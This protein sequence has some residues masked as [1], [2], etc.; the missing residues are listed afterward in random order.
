[1]FKKSLIAASLALA[2]ASAQASV[3]VS[4]DFDGAGGL[5]GPTA[6]RALDWSPN[7]IL[8]TSTVAGKNAANPAVGD[9]VQTYAQA[10]LGSAIAAD[11]SVFNPLGLNNPSALGYEWTFVAGFREVISGFQGSPG[12]GTVNLQTISGGINFFEVWVSAKD[13]NALAGTGYANGTKILGGSIDAYNPTTDV[14]KSSF[15]TTSGTTVLPLDGSNGDDYP[16]LLSVTGSG[17]ADLSA[18]VNLNFIDSNY[19]TDL[20]AGDLLFLQTNL[21]L[22]FGQVDP[23]ALVAGQ[24]GA[25]VASIGTINGIDG[26]NLLL[27]SDAAS[28]FTHKVPEP[29]TL[30]LAG[31]ALFGAQLSRRRSSN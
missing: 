9:I 12:N 23:S 27:Q 7:S 14:G 2:A 6:I 1:M 5:E 26:P 30:A 3:S 29:A 16:G 22:P 25:N 24:P 19:F 4:I 17:T 10:T 18:T 31:L 11:G 8:I 13:S 21:G 28:N 15:T 20:K